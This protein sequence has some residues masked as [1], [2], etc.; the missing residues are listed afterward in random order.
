[1]ATQESANSTIL[2]VIRE[3]LSFWD[4]KRTMTMA[5]WS[6][7]LYTP[8]YIGLYRLYDRYLP[9]Q[10][11]ASIA[12]RVALSFLT[13]I[14]VN[15][16]FYT[17]GA[18]AHHTMEWMDSR[19]K[20]QVELEELGLDYVSAYQAATSIPYPEEAFWA[21]AQH[22]LETELH[23]TVVTSGSCWIPFNLF[24]FTMVPSH[25]RPISLMV[26]SAF[27]NCYLSL[28]QHREAPPA[29]VSADVDAVIL[30]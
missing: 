7:C 24:T 5:A 17:Y 10:T 22:K 29:E 9:K 23:N 11:P 27:W 6:V 12:A 14:P 26:F 20:L 18:A 15:A 2:D 19:K 3:E 16:A 8:F 30:P 21:K 1:M 25:L 13:S 4:P 28:S